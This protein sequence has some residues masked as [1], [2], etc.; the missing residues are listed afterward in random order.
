M[1]FAAIIGNISSIVWILPI[2]RQYK[3][4]MFYFFLV[5]GLADPLNMLAV[6]VLKFKTCYVHSIAAILLFYSL[7]Y[8]ENRKL[9]LSYTD[10]LVGVLFITMVFFC[11]GNYIS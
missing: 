11:P 5:L 1:H 7:N 2:F 6:M 9:K 8:R 4:R 10:L 3:T